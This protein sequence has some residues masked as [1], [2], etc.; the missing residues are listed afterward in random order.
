MANQAYGEFCRLF[1][2]AEQKIKQVENLCDQLPIPAV[3]QLRGAGFHCSR[4]LAAD[5]VEKERVNIDSATMHCKRALY[6]A[7]EIAISFLIRK[8]DLF[9]KDYRWV[10]VGKVV[11]ATYLADLQCIREA[12]R[13]IESLSP[14]DMDLKNGTLEAAQRHWETLQ[15]ISGTFEIA[16]EELDK[17]LFRWRLG[18][19]ISILA[20]LAAVLRLLL[21]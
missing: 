14:H 12:Q 10:P 7:G 2:L 3:N 17:Y 19:L 16:R 18:T 9:R 1:D 8:I 20:L 5:S 11:G 13:F 15:R 4:A 6:D 21:R